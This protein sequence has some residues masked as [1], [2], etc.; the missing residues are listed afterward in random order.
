MVRQKS[1]GW[2]VRSGSGSQPLGTQGGKKRALLSTLVKT[3]FTSGEGDSLFLVSRVGLVEEVPV[4]HSPDTP[5]GSGGP[6]AA[7]QVGQR[8]VPDVGPA[9]AGQSG[10]GLAAIVGSGCGAVGRVGPVV[11]PGRG[12][13]GR[14]SGK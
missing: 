10:R 11:A 4:L 12:H 13:C 5:R 7:T 3:R 8:V 6:L 1:K 14:G 2:R 9:G